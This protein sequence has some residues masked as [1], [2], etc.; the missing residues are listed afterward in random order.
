MLPERE[1]DR[2]NIKLSPNGLFN[3]RGHELCSIV[4]CKFAI[5]SLLGRGIDM[6]AG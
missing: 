6:V 1:L 5:Q 3:R 4:F 2:K